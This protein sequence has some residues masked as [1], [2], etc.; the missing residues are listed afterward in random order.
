MDRSIRK[1]RHG[2]YRYIRTAHRADRIEIEIAANNA[3]VHAPVYRGIHVATPDI[4]RPVERLGFWSNDRRAVFRVEIRIETTFLTPADVT[5]AF[6]GGLYGTGQPASWE[7]GDWN[8]DGVF[9]E[10]DSGI[11]S[12]CSYNGVVT[13]APGNGGAP[14]R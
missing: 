1:P 9:N 3:E 6:K 11:R 8:E 2:I 10:R 5:L 12:M 13:Y 7:T 14:N 4:R